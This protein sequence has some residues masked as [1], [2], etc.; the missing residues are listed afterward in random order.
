MEADLISIFS[1]KPVDMRCNVVYESSIYI[2]NKS[3]YSQKRGENKA[4]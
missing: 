4:F 3:N 1:H 2:D